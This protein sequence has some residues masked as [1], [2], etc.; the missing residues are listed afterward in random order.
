MVSRE[1]AV[2]LVALEATRERAE[3]LVQPVLA[4]RAT[5]A[6][7][8]ELRRLKAVIGAGVKAWIPEDADEADGASAPVDVL[9]FVH[10]LDE[11]V[12]VIDRLF[13]A[14]SA[15]RLYR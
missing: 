14:S 13:P 12:D 4:A 10:S 5:V 15:A 7:Q 6:E 11:V 1:P 2:D 8:E 3:L 9:R